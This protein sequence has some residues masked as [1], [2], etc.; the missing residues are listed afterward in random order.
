MSETNHVETF[1]C[2]HCGAPIE[3]YGK[4]ERTVRCSFCGNSAAVPESIL[5]R[6]PALQAAVP[7]AGLNPA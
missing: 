5:P 2:P 6:D 7:L 4:G 3:Y 1:N